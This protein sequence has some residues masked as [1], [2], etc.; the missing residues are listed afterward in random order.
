M[1]YE[2]TEEYGL[3]AYFE[4]LIWSQKQPDALSDSYYSM[5]FGALLA[6]ISLMCQTLRPSTPDSSASGTITEINRI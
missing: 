5:F 3:Y 2:K 1:F 4:H 6:E